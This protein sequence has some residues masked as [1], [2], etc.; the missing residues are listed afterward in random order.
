MKKEVDKNLV[1]SR[2]FSGRL[3]ISLAASEKLYYLQIDL[4]DIV[5]D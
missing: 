3:N 2:V 5:R 1:N 4:F